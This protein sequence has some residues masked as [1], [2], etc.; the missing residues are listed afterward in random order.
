MVAAELLGDAGVPPGVV[1]VRGVVISDVSQ[2]LGVP[3]P[4]LRSWELRYGIPS[5][6]HVKGRHR[7]YSPTDLHAVRMM[8]DEI[9]RG[10]RAAVAAQAVQRLLEPPEPQAGFIDHFLAATARLDGLAVQGVLDDADAELGL[11][12]CVDEVLLPGLRQVG[13]WWATGRCDAGP[14]RLAT[15]SARGWL[16]RYRSTSGRSATARTAVLAC[17]PR[18]AHTL[19]LEALAA[20]LGARGW[21]CH[22]LGAHTGEA[23]LTA[24]ITDLTPAA[25]VLVS[26]LASSRRAVVDCLTAAQQAGP[27]VFYAGNA[28]TGHHR[29]PVPGTYL[30]A[31]I[32]PAGDIVI[33]T[34]T[35]TAAPL[36]LPKNPIE[37]HAR[38]A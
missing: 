23:A 37:D 24:A 6:S 12:R 21:E 17:G 2:W 35:E 26:H 31:D 19:G 14:E 4:T 16:Y 9:A 22:V 30:G 8:R 13:T 32:G 28:F 25:V 18:D 5:R 10:R 34:A 1:A 20:V 36:R 11:A 38:L 7:R 33:D 3:M 29:S 15:Q 27:R